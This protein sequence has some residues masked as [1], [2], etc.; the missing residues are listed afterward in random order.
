MG[1]GRP[2]MPSSL[3]L[4]ASACPR[5][6]RRCELRAFDAFGID[7]SQYFHF[8]YSW[9]RTFMLWCAID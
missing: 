1:Y 4:I 2:P 9:T 7:V 8:L 5:H 3:A 6:G